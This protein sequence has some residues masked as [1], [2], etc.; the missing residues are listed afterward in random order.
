MKKEKFKLDI[1]ASV[2]RVKNTTK[3]FWW[4]SKNKRAQIPSAPEE[5][6]PCLNFHCGPRIWRI[7]FPKHCIL[8]RAS[9]ITKNIIL[10]KVW[11]GIH[12]TFFNPTLQQ[13]KHLFISNTSIFKQ[14]FL[15]FIIECDAFYYF[16]LY[17]WK[18][19]LVSRKFM[20]SLHV[21]GCSEHDF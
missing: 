5:F 15:Y 17:E 21:L 9:A 12:K 16:L 11:C 1:P 3:D 14:Y 4:R 8:K 10:P 13:K 18:K 2:E 20:M 19:L 7:P 6:L